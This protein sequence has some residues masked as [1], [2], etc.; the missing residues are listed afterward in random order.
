MIGKVKRK[1]RHFVEDLIRSTSQDKSLEKIINQ[2]EVRIIGLK[3]SGNHAVSNWMMKQ[4]QGE[5]FYINDVGANENPYREK[6][7]AW[8]RS[9]CAK[10]R[11]RLK[12][13]SQG[14]FIEK[15]YLIYSYEDYELNRITNKNFANKHDLYFGKTATRYDV[16]LL[17]DPFNL[18]AS[19]FKKG[20]FVNQHYLGTKNP[21]LSVVDLWLSYAKEWLGETQY[22]EYNRVFINYNKWFSDREYRQSLSSQLNLEFSDQGINQVKSQGGGSSFDARNFHN[23]ATQMDVLN[24]WKNYA[25]NPSYREVFRNEELWNYSQEIFG[26]IPG[27]EILKK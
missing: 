21:Q 20:N 3:R 25:D 24:R 9:N 12:Q 15:D 19:R 7:E 11:E 14:N 17:R 13:E 16:I 5:V 1:T 6:Y 4:M 26:H 2:N 23:N 10:N 22:L 27:T 18:I 8:V